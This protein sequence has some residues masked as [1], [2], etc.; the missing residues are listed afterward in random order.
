MNEKSVFWDANTYDNI[1]N[2]HENWANNIIKKKEWTGKENL[3]DAGCG[4]RR[5]TKNTL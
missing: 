4:S 1:S 3:L 5:V 2:I